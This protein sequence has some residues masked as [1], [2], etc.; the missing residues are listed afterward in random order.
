[1]NAKLFL[2]CFVSAASAM[3][4]DPPAGFDSTVPFNSTVLP[5]FSIY[6]SSTWK[7]DLIKPKPAVPVIVVGRD[8]VLNS[9]LVEGLRKL[10]PQEDLSRGQRF[11]RL[12][13]IRLL[14][15]KPMPTPPGTGR[16]FAWRNCSQAWPDA[17]SRPAIWKGP[18]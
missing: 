13:I 2:V 10:P 9:P 16:Y 14:V 11:L 15:P 18:E 12:P 6:D 1:M 8:F 17:A 4:A 7:S 3:A 5:P